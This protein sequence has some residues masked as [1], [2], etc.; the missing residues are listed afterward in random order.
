[1]VHYRAQKIK[2]ITRIIPESTIFGPKKG[3]VLV[4]GW[5]STY[6]AITTA[7]EKLQKEGLSV[8]ALHLRYIN[9]FPPDL[10]E[11]LSRFEK[12]VIPELNL[13]QLKELIQARYLIKAIGIN[14]VTGQPFTIDELVGSLKNI[15]ENGIH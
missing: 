5:G 14:K 6:G 12:V 7:V 13:G 3:N 15:L 11:I 1:M 4:L 10:G 8:S 9:P 2:N